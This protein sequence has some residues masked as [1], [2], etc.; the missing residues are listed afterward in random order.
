MADVLLGT[1]IFLLYALLI[2][3][4][5]VGLIGLL[6]CFLKTKPKKEKKKNVEIATISISLKVTP[7][8]E[9]SK[10][11]NDFIKA[12]EEINEKNK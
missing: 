7:F 1:V 5:I 4:S 8:V 6:N 9:T 3:G 11:M 10:S 2:A 12:L